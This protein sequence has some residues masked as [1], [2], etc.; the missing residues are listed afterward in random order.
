M[1]KVYAAECE[2]QMVKGVLQFGLVI[3]IDSSPVD[4]IPFLRVLPTPLPKH[5]KGGK[6]L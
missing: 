5:T 4:G 6:L 1:E 2:A 3:D